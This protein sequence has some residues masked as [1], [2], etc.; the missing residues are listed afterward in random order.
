M[1]N[2]KHSSLTDTYLT[3]PDIVKA[4]NTT[5]LGINLDPC[6]NDEINNTW[7]YADKIYTAEDN[8]LL[9]TWRINPQIQG[10]VLLNPPG[11]VFK[12]Q[13]NQSRFLRKAYAQDRLGHVHSLIY[14]GFQLS[15]LRIDQDIV[16]QFPHIIPRSR[17][18]FWSWHPIE[19]KFAQGAWDAKKQKWSDQPSHDNVIIYFPPK[20]DWFGGLSRFQRHFGKYGIIQNW[21]GAGYGRTAA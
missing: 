19:N 12:G 4:A 2:V 5:L 8:S 10:R 1:T 6:T 7:V 21:Q 15:I 13:S 14:I 18:H 20:D 17:L 3:P 16:S 9:K 11:G